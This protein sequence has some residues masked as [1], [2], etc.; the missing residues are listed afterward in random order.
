VSEVNSKETDPSEPN[1]GPLSMNGTHSLDVR[2]DLLK[3]VAHITPPSGGTPVSEAALL[4]A[5]S[6]EGIDS[7]RINLDSLEEAVRANREMSIVV[8]R[9]LTSVKGADARFIS[10]VKGITAVPV[11]VNEAELVDYFDLWTYTSVKAGMPLMQRI[12]PTGGIE[13]VNVRGAR[14][15]VKAGKSIKFTKSKGA[16]IDP[17]N[18]HLLI[19]SR[20]GHPV[21]QAQGVEVDD[22]LI[23][24]KASLETGHIDFNGSV[25]INGDV[26][27]QVEIRASGD[28]FVK[29]T[30]SNAKLEAAHDIVIGGGVLSQGGPN[31]EL[32]SHL[33]TSEIIAGNSIQALFLNQTVAKSG[34]TID[35]QRYVLNSELRAKETI[36]LG[37][38]GGK[39]AI[40]GGLAVAAFSITANVVGSNAYLAS[41]LQCAVPDDVH[42]RNKVLTQ[43]LEKR[44]LEVNEL[45]LIAKQLNEHKTGQEHESELTHQKLLKIIRTIKTLRLRVELIEKKTL[46]ISMYSAKSEKA[47]I[48]IDR[49]VYPNTLLKIG[50]AVKLISTELRQTHAVCVKGELISG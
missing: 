2:K 28:I 49:Q 24:A 44:R 10:L 15:P 12:P 36:Y 14:L 34:N 45:I 41:E 25:A 17:E 22:M 4:S 30:V 50:T 31:S 42:A 13:G 21:L 40:I 19:A 43:E 33:I 29:G 37:Q 20:D 39:G 7:S 47:F 11:K 6:A 35:I 26:D 5:L 9:G 3:V 23:L 32:D 48:H 1:A 38:S 18:E 27:S 46:E 8:A 16:E